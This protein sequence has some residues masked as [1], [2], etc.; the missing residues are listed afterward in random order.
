MREK[1]GGIRFR[2]PSTAERNGYGEEKKRTSVKQNQH[3][4]GK[5]N[6]SSHC[7][8]NS[9]CRTLSPLQVSCRTQKGTK[10]MPSVGKS[11]DGKK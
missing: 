11:C 7:N 1:K 3:A 6:I 4:E 2:G 9:K 10:R 8:G 5:E